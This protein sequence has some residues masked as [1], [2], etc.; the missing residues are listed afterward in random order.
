LPKKAYDEPQCPGVSRPGI[1]GG[2]AME[3]IILSCPDGYELACMKASDKD[4]CCCCCVSVTS[5]SRTSRTATT[6][7]SSP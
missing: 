1:Q 7:S 5:P 3:D 6:V 4:K 2:C